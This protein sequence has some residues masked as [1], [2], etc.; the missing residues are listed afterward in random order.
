MLVQTILFMN[1]KTVNSANTA[2]AKNG[3]FFAIRNLQLFSFPHEI[4]AAY[5]VRLRAQ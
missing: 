2:P 4:V 5:L 3:Y 1:I